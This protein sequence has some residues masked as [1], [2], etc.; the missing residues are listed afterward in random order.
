MI[1]AV[2][3]DL[4]GTLVETEELKAISHAR[5]VTELRPEVPEE[6][7]ISA[8]GDDLVGH[9]RQEIAETLIQRFELEEAIRERMAELSEDEPWRALVRIRRAIYEEILKDSNLIV[10]KRYQHNIDLLKDLRSQGYPTACATMSHREQVRRVLSV[11][12]LEDTFDI[13]V[14]M[15]DVERGKPDPEIDLLVAAKM[16]VPPEEFLVIEDSAAGV[17]AGVA[18]GMAVV[19]VPT[20]LTRKGLRASGVLESQWVVEDP[21]TLPDVVRRRIADAGG[22]REGDQ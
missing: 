10:E 5:S 19:A 17:G 15:D 13:V 2:I 7:V 22:K 14:T 8:Y 16:G 4:D 1:S 20:R 21:G 6:D 3:F 12:D 9:S 18:A 11:L